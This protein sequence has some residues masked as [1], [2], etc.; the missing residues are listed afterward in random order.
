MPVVPEAICKPVCSVSFPQE[1]KV[2]CPSLQANVLVSRQKPKLA[3][4]IAFKKPIW[5][6]ERLA[7]ELLESSSQR[8]FSCSFT[9]E[10][11]LAFQI[12]LHACKTCSRH[13][14]VALQ[15]PLLVLFVASLLPKSH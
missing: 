7:S 15:Q 2:A 11:S 10:A 12:I 6:A 4:F 3:F 5:L 8:G 14:H 13:M 1:A 9:E